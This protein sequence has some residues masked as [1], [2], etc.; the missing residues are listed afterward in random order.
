MTANTRKTTERRATAWRAA[1]GFEKSTAPVKSPP[2]SGNWFIQP[3]FLGQTWEIS[4]LLYFFLFFFLVQCRKTQV[5]LQHAGK[6]AGGGQLVRRA[7]RQGGAAGFL[8]R[9]ARAAKLL[10]E[11]NELEPIAEAYTALR[12]AQ[13]EQEEARELLAGETD[14][15]MKELC[16]SSFSPPM[17]RKPNYWKVVLRM[18]TMYAAARGWTA[19]DRQHQRNGAWRREGLLCRY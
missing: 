18:Y 10:K 1:P 2:R 7:V 4:L 13:Q 12:Q 14:P 9:S 5:R 17:K 6:I 16:Q 11:R 3:T 19:G 8:R 15:D